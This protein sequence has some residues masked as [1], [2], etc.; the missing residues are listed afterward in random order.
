M[1]TAMSRTERF[2]PVF[3]SRVP[4]ALEDG[5]LYVSM[6][7]ATTIHSCACGCRREVVTPLRPGKWR[8]IYD[9]EVTLRPSI[10]NWSQP[11]RSHYF[12]VRN[13]VVWARSWSDGE[14]AAA[15]RRLQA[16]SA[17]RAARNR[18]TG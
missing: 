6:D 3:V 16:I 4:D 7:Y 15:R 8:L 12:I 2:H 18:D 10:G 9:G 13:R 1:P 5:L 17:S 11:C 14:V